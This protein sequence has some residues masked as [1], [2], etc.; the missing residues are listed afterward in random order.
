MVVS[1]CSNV[2]KK[3]MPHSWYGRVLPPSTVTMDRMANGWGS[4]TQVSELTYRLRQL[5]TGMRKVP[6]VYPEW[7]IDGIP[8]VDLVGARARINRPAAEPNPAESMLPP[9]IWFHGDEATARLLLEL[10]ADLP[11]GRH[12]LL[13]C[14]ECGDAGCGVISA[15]IERTSEV[16]VWRDFGSETN[17]Y[18]PDEPA[19][20]WFDLDTLA[21]LG[22]YTFRRG[23]YE[24]TVREMQR[25]GF[26]AFMEWR[27]LDG[28]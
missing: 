24:R 19:I 26:A 14:P 2:S 11:S 21:G 23:P 22:P 17:Y 28:V 12:S 9:M 3:V 6:R 5:P 10:P 27:A 25:V 16:V 4:I 20:G 8:F 18:D 13:V 15:I 7:V 1:I